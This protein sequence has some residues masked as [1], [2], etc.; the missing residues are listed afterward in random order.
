MPDE[1]PLE[2][3]LLSHAAEIRISQQLDEVEKIDIDVQ[4]DLLKIVQGKAEAVSVTGQGLVIQ[5]DIRV[6]EIKLQTDNISI[7]PFSALLGQIK[8][9]EPVNAVARIIL[10]ESDINH[11]LQTDFIRDFTE[12]LQLDIDGETLSL[13]LQETQVLLPE[14]SKIELKG[15]LLIKERE[16]T[17]PL[18]YTV[19]ISPRFD[20]KTLMVESFNCIEG[21]GISLEFITAL[22]KKVKKLLKIRHLKWEDMT[23]S[24]KDIKAEKNSLKLLVEAYV[25]QIPSSSDILYP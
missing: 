19:R 23:I 22:L 9:D 21:E 10:T 25:K 15:R 5:E 16:N 6:Q 1:Q 12:N 7:S 14:D 11:I 18:A 4:T 24:I 3:Q 17:Q 8:L 2:A 20:S 13:D